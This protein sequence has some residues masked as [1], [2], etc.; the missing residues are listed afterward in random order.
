MAGN[1][2]VP[3]TIVEGKHADIGDQDIV[4]I[5]LEDYDFD[6]YTNIEDVWIR[7]LLPW[8]DVLLLKI[9]NQDEINDIKRRV[10]IRI[11]YL[12]DVRIDW[13]GQNMITCD[14]RS[15]VRNRQTRWD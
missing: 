5:R 11:G 4:A 8:L 13:Y 7:D 14:K 6:L 3:V 15:S 1:Q 2:F 12:E 10:L 9:L